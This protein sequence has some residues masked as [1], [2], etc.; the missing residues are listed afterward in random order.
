[1]VTSYSVQ[2]LLIR[3]DAN[4]E[5]GTGHLMRCLAL[6]KVWRTTGIFKPLLFQC[7]LTQFVAM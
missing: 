6:D 7:L 1:M 5:I 4:I 2:P 3:A